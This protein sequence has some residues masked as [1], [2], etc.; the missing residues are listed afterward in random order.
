MSDNG[1]QFVNSKTTLYD[2][3]VRIPP[4]LSI[5]QT[6]SQLHSRVQPLSQ[7]PHAD[8]QI[9]NGKLVGGQNYKNIVYF[10]DGVSQKIVNAVAN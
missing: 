3:R 6:N 2:A 4:S 7:R 5:R 9:C 8:C 10:R 1:A